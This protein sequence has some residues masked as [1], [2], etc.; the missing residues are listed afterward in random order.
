MQRTA[1]ILAYFIVC[2][3]CFSQQYPFVHYTPKDG[4]V[5][6][7]VKK[8][9]QDSKG[10]MYFLTYGGLSVFDGARFRNYTTQN[11]MATNLVNDILEVGEDSLL[12]ATNFHS[13]NALVKGKI[14]TI[15]VE[16]D[17][18]PLINQFYRHEDDKIYLSSDD[19]LFLLENKKITEL[20][21]SVLQGRN[22]ELPYLD[23]I[24]GSGNYL[25][26]TT[27]EMSS[28][29]GLF[30]YD[31]VN[32]R[33]CDALPN[34]NALLLGKDTK[35]GVWISMSHKLFVLDEMALTRG[36]ISL[37]PPPGSYG[38]AKD[39]SVI[40]LAF[41]NKSLWLV[42]RDENFIDKEIHRIDESGSLLRIP[43]PEQATTLGIGHIMIDREN[44]IWLSNYGG[45]FK[46]VNS[47]LLI[48]EKPFNSHKEIDRAFYLNNVTWFNTFSNKILASSQNGT[49]ELNCNLGNAPF[50]FYADDKKL[51]AHDFW[52]IYQAYLPDQKKTVAFQTI[53]TIE[54]PDLFG[55]HFLVDPNGNFITSQKTGLNV[56]KK[57]RLVFH[58][59]IP[60]DDNIEGLYLD[61]KNL[62]WVVKRHSGIDV[63]SLHPEDVSNYLQTVFHFGKDQLT[64]STR[65]FVIDKNGLIWVGTREYGLFAYKREDR[66][67]LSYHFD[68]DNGVT[69]N[70]ITALACD[71]MNNIIVGTQTGL[72]RILFG[73]NTSWRIENLSKSSNF[74]SFINQ[75]WADAN[76]QSYALTTSRILLQ[77]S[78]PIAEKTA[79]HPRLILEEMRVNA[80][81]V[82]VQK[83]KFRH[84][85]NNLSFFVAAPSFIDEKQVA[86]S[87]LLEG[88]G[89]KQW[90]DT[91]SVNSVINLT[92]LSAEKYLLK[93]KAFF[94]STSYAVAE[95]SYPF[96]IMPPWW[97]T[98]WF[99]SIAALIIIGLLIIGFRFYYRRKLEKQM[100]ALEKQQA[101]E[102]ERTRIATDMHDDL[103]AGL[104]RIKFLSE[105]VKA[106]KGD[107]EAML[108][109][110]EKI[111]A[112]S[113]EMAAKMGEIVWA[114]NKKNDTVA[115]LVAFT[116]SYVLEYL[117]GQNIRCELNTPLTLP[118]TFIAGEIRQHIFLSVKECLHN[119]V[120][121]AGASQ[122]HFSV[123]L[124][125]EIEI[126]IHD[127]GKG[128]NWNTMRP[129]S[130]GIQN[131]Q[132]RMNEIHGK[133]TFLNEK[134]TKVIMNIPHEV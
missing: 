65:C 111:S 29:Q 59:P 9:Y 77:L 68:V 48:F 73:S 88:S 94:P 123:K 53:I 107:N 22:S 3:N 115:D 101:I 70:F 47:R 96:E 130:N 133:V 12:V 84:T 75:A 45:V 32:N 103:G 119:I 131:I 1:I 98:W 120:K 122:V 97:Q 43:L 38:I 74:F 13:L 49:R 31:I 87:Y 17:G 117:S 5:N 67:K 58:V 33:I 11:G 25:I 82:D 23:N 6:S 76:G 92:N 41:N 89:N 118:S 112:Y 26:L 124:N 129:F 24:S 46:I 106:N 8:A 110:I 56:W 100:A 44:T 80:Q 108:K 85:E 42:H 105:N 40:N 86:F 54:K 21:I 113:E 62:L 69:D 127:N 57:N 35:N 39:Y 93:V 109:D 64:G 19:G 20:N 36:K 30:L 52:N 95:F 66:L 50:I 2:A 91:T 83:N 4:L 18:C 51:I 61:K 63:C 114:L 37:I 99:R 60:R 81:T 102:K 16:A 128:I 79:Y 104:S 126:I 132:R 72:D 78:A 34:V 125:G 71:S 7:R 134:G 15:K 10:R 121:H 27:N 90:S 28:Q 14:K 55:M 116:R